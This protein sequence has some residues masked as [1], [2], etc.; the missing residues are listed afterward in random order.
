MR[1]QSHAE[2]HGS[3]WMILGSMVMM[4]G[5][6][7]PSLIGYLL[8]AINGAWLFLMREIARREGALGSVSKKTVIAALSVIALAVVFALKISWLA[9]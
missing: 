4:A 5:S 2:R 1:F 3:T 7:H 6:A 8:I 9:L